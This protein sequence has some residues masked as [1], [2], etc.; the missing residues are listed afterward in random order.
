[1]QN[2]FAGL[3]KNRKARQ[4]QGG[5]PTTVRRDTRTQSN[6]GVLS[7]NAS[8]RTTAQPL[9]N[10]PDRD[11]P[12]PFLPSRTR[13][14]CACLPATFPRGAAR[15]DPRTASSPMNNARAMISWPMFTRGGLSAATGAR[16]RT[17]S[18]GPRAV[19]LRA[20]RLVGARQ[21]AQFRWRASPCASRRPRVVRRNPPQPPRW[22]RSADPIDE[23]ATAPISWKPAV[24]SRKRSSCA[25]T[26]RPPSVVTSR[27]SGTGRPPGGSGARWRDPVRGAYLEFIRTPSTSFSWKTSRS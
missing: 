19:Q 14:R 15:P 17:V 24:T 12:C 21:A 20:P 1:M 25:A 23:Q 3:S 9:R 4:R 7:K 11:S 10:P 26:S 8:P 18:R 5:S 13:S 2:C 6:N 27:C 16:L 22:R